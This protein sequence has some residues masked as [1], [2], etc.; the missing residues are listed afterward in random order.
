LLAWAGSTAASAQT[1]ALCSDATACNYNPAITGDV[2]ECNYTD[3][4]GCKELLACN[5]NAD[6]TIQDNG[7]CAF[8]LEN[9]CALCSWKFPRQRRILARRRWCT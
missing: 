9:T 7:S 4:A 6:A 1:S 8:A 3:C 5:Y 2:S